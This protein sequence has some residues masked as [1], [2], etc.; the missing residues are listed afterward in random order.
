MNWLWCN[1]SKNDRLPSADLFDKVKDR[2]KKLYSQRLIQE[3]YIDDGYQKLYDACI[4]A[5]HGTHLF[6][7]GI[8]IWISVPDLNS[9]SIKK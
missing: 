8:E 1:S 5:Y 2:N 9:M 3:D 7:K 6:F 4:N